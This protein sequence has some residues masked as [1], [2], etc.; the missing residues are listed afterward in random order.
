MSFLLSAEPSPKRKWWAIGIATVL[1]AVSFGSFV[2]ALVAAG[3]DDPEAAGP[4]FALG[5]ILVP[6]VF[7]VLAFVSGHDRAPI[8][9]LQGMGIWLLLA[10]PVGLFNP[11]TGLA[12][13]FGGGGVLA[14][15]REEHQSLRPRI[16]GTILT[17]LYVTLTLVI[18]VPAGL[19]AGALLPLT[20]LGL[21]DW[22][23]ERRR[24]AQ[25]SQPE[26]PE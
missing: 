7:A 4:A 24:G 2:I 9:T 20:A 12:A 10:L 16:I 26:V 19:F 15:R 17:T 22:Y 14:L 6:A 13:G 21:S 25:P 23:A 11:V 18:F 8:G 5:F 1:M 3:S